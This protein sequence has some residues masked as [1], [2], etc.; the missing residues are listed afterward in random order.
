MVPRSRGSIWRPIAAPLVD[1]L[2]GGTGSSLGIP[3][4]AVAAWIFADKPTRPA[5][6]VDN[7]TLLDQKPGRTSRA[8]VA[9]TVLTTNGTTQ[10][11]TFNQGNVPQWN[12]GDSY[13][14]VI[15]F[16]TTQSTGSYFEVWENTKSTSARHGCKMNTSGVV[17]FSNYNGS[18]YTGVESSRSGY[19]DGQWHCCV[20]VSTSGTLSL[21]LD[22][23]NV[24]AASAGG[25]LSSTKLCQ[26][27]LLA[28]GSF[29]AA[30]SYSQFAMYNRPLTA[31]EIETIAGLQRR[32]WE[33]CD[34][35]SDYVFY[36]PLE[37]Y[38]TTNNVVYSVAGSYGVLVNYAAGMNEATGQ[39]P[40][41]HCNHH[42]TS[43]A[44]RYNGSTQY[45]TTTGFTTA[46]IPASG[47]AEWYFTCHTLPGA[48]KGFYNGA[49]GASGTSERFFAGVLTSVSSNK[50]AIGFGDLGATTTGASAY[51]VDEGDYIALRVE[52]NG[53][54]CNMY[55][56]KNTET[57]WTKY[58]DA[59]AYTH[60]F[61]S[62]NFLLGVMNMNGTPDHYSNVTMLRFVCYN[63]AG[64]TVYDTAVSGFGSGTNAPGTPSFHN[65][66]D[67]LMA[68]SDGTPVSGG[69]ASLNGTISG[70]VGGDP[71]LRAG[72]SID[73]DGVANDP[74]LH[75]QVLPTSHSHGG[76][77]AGYSLIK[78][79]VDGSLEK[80][81]YIRK[82]RYGMVLGIGNSLLNFSGPRTLLA[83]PGWCWES[84]HS[85]T[86]MTDLVADPTTNLQG[87]SFRW[88]LCLASQP[89]EVVVVQ[90]FT[91]ETGGSTS[92]PTFGGERDAILEVVDA[93]TNLQRLVIFTGYNRQADHATDRVNAGP[94]VDNDPMIYCEFFF[95]Q[96]R[97]EIA[98]AN[99]GI[100]VILC[101]V[102]SMYD[103]IYDDIVGATSYYA[104]WANLY[105]DGTHP[106]GNVG[107]L[108]N[109]AIR[110]AIK[111]VAACNPASYRGYP[112]AA[113][114]TAEADYQ[115][116]ILDEVMP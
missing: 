6:A 54:T 26:L 45:H 4:D 107:R 88:D 77:L 29:Y 116:A 91:A 44:A 50:A 34:L 85:N 76:S 84:I 113:I 18:V 65:D 90:P 69:H 105:S 40:W 31:N 21:W 51:T 27:G 109:A 36:C 47:S 112:W 64:A 19:N 57:T 108:A 60:S 11:V 104:A 70:Y 55:L 68:F 1:K 30:G 62:R 114:P 102:W 8:R 52:W 82:P 2:V 99:P 20:C 14:V 73:I 80:R 17:S 42:G 93:A 12:V 25:N 33:V 56:K 15:W 39:A 59:Q 71:I 87:D 95:H 58:L 83:A 38:D 16:R 32:P 46:N 100:D 92:G 3:G 10:Y 111:P 101:D 37:I 97:G 35:P 103:A 7:T 94:F 66:Q 48:T 89:V 22:G 72:D 41:C 106:A 74:A 78:G 5:V 75:G 79:L 49:A 86:S 67:N 115:D 23:V 110:R 9:G 43:L 28:N 81:F 61:G 96:L 24:T 63:A 53:T 13:S 98:T